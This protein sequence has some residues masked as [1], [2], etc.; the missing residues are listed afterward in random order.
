GLGPARLIPLRR[1]I[2]RAE[3]WPGLVRPPRPLEPAPLLPGKIVLR[4]LLSRSLGLSGR[5]L[6]GGSLH[7]RSLLLGDRTRVLRGLVLGLLAL[8]HVLF[9]V[10]RHFLSS[11]STSI[12]R[13]RATVSIFATS[14]RVVPRR[15]VFSSSP[16][17]CRKRRLNASSLASISFATSS[18]SFM[19]WTSE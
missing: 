12:P 9:L 6:L 11:L 17:A 3:L 19:L 8:V 7:G 2:L 16:V 4:V 18:S 5:R 14:R 1:P 15:A 13:S 10:V